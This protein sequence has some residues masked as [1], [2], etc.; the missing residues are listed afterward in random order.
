MANDLSNLSK[1]QLI[2]MIPADNIPAAPSPWLL[3]TTGYA[4]TA[5][6]VIGL[7]IAIV[8]FIR[9][10]RANH[11]R[12]DALKQ[13][14]TLSDQAQINLLLKQVALVALGRNKVASLSGAPWYELLFQHSGDSFWQKNQQALVAAQYGSNPS[15]IQ[16]A[17]LKQATEQF[18]RNHTRASQ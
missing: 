3:S 8:L 15:D 12:R 6:L 9:H 11:Y 5:L 14:A 4:L 18:I 13:L 7:T 10:W 17:A 1:E 16:L 2:A